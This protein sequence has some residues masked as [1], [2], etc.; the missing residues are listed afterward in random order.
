MAQNKSTHTFEEGLIRI[1]NKSKQPKNSYSFGLNLVTNNNILDRT[2]RSNEKGFDDYFDIKPL[3]VFNI[4]GTQWLGNEEYLFFIKHKEGGF[5]FNEIRL[6]NKKD[7][8]NVLLY[9]NLLL[10]FQDNNEITSTFRIN[11]KNQRVVY[12]VDGLNDDRVI[13][14]DI[15]SSLL[16]I[17]LLSIE[18]SSKKPIIEATVNDTGGSVTTG[19]YFI[20]ISYN[21]GNSFTTEP[22]SISSPISIGVEKYYNN[23]VVNNNNSKEFGLTDG[24][25]IPIPT[26][27]SISLNITNIDINYDTYNIIISKVANTGF[28][29]KVIKKISVKVNNFLYTGNEGEED[30]T[31][32]IQDLTSGGVKYYASE[33][34]SQKENRLLRGNS[35]LKGSFIQYQKFANNIK[36]DYLITEKVV[37]DVIER[38]QDD[39]LTEIGSNEYY[40]RQSISP[41]YLSNTANNDLD[42]KTFMRDEVYS[43]GIGFELIDGSETDVF[44][45]PGRLLNDVSNFASGEYNRDSS[46]KQSVWDNE[47]INSNLYWKERNTATTFINS[48]GGNL[49][50]WRS[51]EVYKDG[52]DLPKNGEKNSDGKSYIR[53]HKMPSDVLQ[54]IFRFETNL[55][56]NSKIYKRSLSLDIKNIV[57]PD[58]LK[59]LI[60][61]VK[62]FYTPREGNNK[63]ILSK[64]L[65]YGLVKTDQVLSRNNHFN[66]NFNANN[67][68]N[69]FEFI[70][71]DVNFKFKEANINGNKI[72]VCGIDK[73]D[74][75]YL[76][77][78]FTF[79]QTFGGAAIAIATDNLVNIF[80]N[81]LYD[82]TKKRQS[83]LSSF[84][85]YSKRAI[86]NSLTYSRNIDKVLYVDGNF[87]GSS[88]DLT[89]DFSGGQPTSVLSLSE[90]IRLKPTL[91]TPYLSVDYPSLQYPTIATKSSDLFA[92]NIRSLNY[93]GSQSENQSKMNEE[94]HNVINNLNPKY[95]T[96]YYI[97]I[98]K[99]I[100]NQYGNLEQLTY[101]NLNKQLVYN[102]TDS[103]LNTNLAGGDTYIDCHYFKTTNIK[104]TPVLTNAGTETIPS[105]FNTKGTV[106]D[107]SYTPDN[108]SFIVQVDEAATQ[109][110]GSFIC[111]TD[112]NIRMRVE[113]QNLPA[114]R[115][116]PKSYYTIT[117]LEDLSRSV[118]NKEYYYINPAYLTNYIKLNFA[119]SSNEEVS[120]ISDDVRYSTRV[121]YSDKQELEDKV[122]NYRTV[123]ANNYRDLPLNRGGITSFFTKQ[124]KLFVITRDSLFNVFASNQSIKTES[125]TN[126]VVG[127][128]EF[129]SIE[130]VEIV[131]IEGG[132][133]GSSSKNSVCETP[134][135]YLFVDKLKNKT[136]LFSDS[137]KDLN[138]T[139]LNENFKIE[140]Y[141]QF[142]QLLNDNIFDNPITSAGIISIFDP[143]LNR[144]LITK[145]DYK[146][147][148]LLL[149][150]FRGVYD[151]T[152]VYYPVDVVMV[153][154]TVVI[155]KNKLVKISENQD[156]QIVNT[157]NFSDWII[158]NNNLNTNLVLPISLPTNGTINSRIDKTINYTLYTNQTSDSFNINQSNK[159]CAFETINI[160]TLGY[161]FKWIP[162][163][164]TAYCETSG[165][166][167]IGDESTSSC[168]Q[169]NLVSYDSRWISQE[170]TAYCEQD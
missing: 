123:R 70:S 2:T 169:S 4:V 49:A 124:D 20:S 88:G 79:N 139:G 58:E 149:S 164:I 133:G 32:N 76:K 159:N 50:Y 95:D 142:P 23:I 43:L 1:D 14:V 163:Q 94:G 34:I 55:L 98:I 19:Q 137:L 157:S 97:S 9:S 38:D 83:F 108:G 12:W 5:Q 119:A 153:K 78:D 117:T 17:S 74:V 106:Y 10:N 63:S 148:A 146:A 81:Q 91:V 168:E 52:F 104:L 46:I 130:P 128:G 127:T 92:N 61:K 41:A 85:I 48:F 135:G 129:L 165:L 166:K 51:S 134:Y 112:I 158:N 62:F 152:I 160:T 111:E 67:Q 87:K 60:S 156:V 22:L 154:N 6:L 44:H 80:N 53:H 93:N 136:L 138:I 18:S 161:N 33:A 3:I 72:K 167:W 150:R 65:A 126:I 25:V 40:A 13:N 145:K 56:N 140:L 147:T 37:R 47:L 99:T 82:D 162:N 105:A 89:I 59:K 66:S 30:T 64:G 100:D 116:Y 69:K 114:Q 15:D 132:F 107:E 151:P 109:S 121:I 68:Y 141:N 36:V 21:V 16:N 144:L 45:I 39:Y 155:Y 24:D 27:K 42:N 102:G 90:D 11:Y 71:P 8:S 26:N 113:G 31:I 96:S 125:D 143:R 84:A 170:S 77:K 35:K 118:T 110:F 28:S 120:L 131:S 103:I 115:Y 75:V 7:N 101:V 86:P 57:I 73:A 29:F 54:P 122:D